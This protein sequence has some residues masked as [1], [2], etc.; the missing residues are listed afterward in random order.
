MVSETPDTARR[1]FMDRARE[2]K[3]DPAA[4]SVEHV[5]D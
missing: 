4:L 3:L 2:C 1:F 5:L